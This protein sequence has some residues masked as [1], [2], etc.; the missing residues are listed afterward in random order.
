MAR[1]RNIKPG[2]FANDLLAEIEPLGRILFAGIWTIA[3]R[4]GRLEDRVKKIK[5]SCLPYDE[6]DCDALLQEL[7]KHGFILRYSVNG[8]AYI[9]VVKW[10][11]HQNPHI[12]EA[13]STIPAPYKNS[14]NQEQDTTQTGTSRADSLN[15]ITDSLNPITSSKPAARDVCS[16]EFEIAWQKYPSRPGASKKEALKAW[17]ARLKAGV[18]VEDMIDG[19][20]RY[21][22]YCDAMKTEPQ[23]IKQPA[24][25][26]GPDE[27]FKAD[28]TPSQPA[29]ASPQGYESAKDRSR[30]EAAEKL[31]GKR[32]NADCPQFTDIN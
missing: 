10:D 17:N 1:A 13:E 30:R 28:W 27:H 6:C 22:A 11:E 26:F 5:A 7:H 19:V 31:T 14:A 24:T 15:P 29:R 9:Q 32:Q 16:A 4:A 3:D 21:A 18:D 25:F 23:Y 20:Q 8:T 2:F 12:K